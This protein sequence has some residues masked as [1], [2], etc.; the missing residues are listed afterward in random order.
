MEYILNGAQM[1]AADTHMIQEVGIPSLVLM[2]R[3]ALACVSVMKKRGVDLSK[4]LV[5]CGSGNNG[6]DGFA[7]ARLLFEEGY[8]PEVVFAGRM[9]SRSE[10]TKLQMDILKKLGMSYGNCLPDREYSVIIDAV[11]GIGLTRPLEGKYKEIIEKMNAVRGVKVAVDIPSGI[12]ADTGQVLGTA[13]CADLTVTFAYRKRGHIFYPGSNYC[14]NVISMPIGIAGPELSEN[15]NVIFS[16]NKEDVPR[17]LPKRQADSNKGTFGK[18]LLI[19][20]SRGMSGAAYLSAKAAYAVGAGLIRIYTEESNRMILQQLLPEAV[21]TTYHGDDEEDALAKLDSLLVWADVTVIGCGLGMEAPGAALLRSVLENYSGPCVVDADALN[22]LSGSKELK[23][24]LKNTRAKC[25]LTPHM[26]EMSRLTGISVDELK[27]RRTEILENYVEEYPV[28][29]IMKDARTMAAKSRRQM[30]L[31]TSGNAALAKGGSGDVLAGMI[32]GFLA[33]GISCFH[34]AVLSIYV[35]GLA[36]EA[37]GKKIGYRSVLA[38]D[39]IDG[40]GETLKSLEEQNEEIQQ[41]ACGH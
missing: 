31:N 3:A 14:G 16:L 1:K 26:K 25:I 36:G 22:I 13:F 34:A 4:A 9:E 18:V 39:I 12:S 21:V 40:I 23:S 19:V 5:V 7:I 6:G 28:V 15:T 24:L 37:A 32:S 2:E 41:S 27:N 17:L 38:R 29:C 33:Q 20:G 8:A 11:F 35:H 10:E 30:Y